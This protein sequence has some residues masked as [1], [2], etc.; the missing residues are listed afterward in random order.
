MPASTQETLHHRHGW[1]EIENSL[2]PRMTLGVI[3]F[4]KDSRLGRGVDGEFVVWEARFWEAE[5]DS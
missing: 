3:E 4:D 5:A 2:I 1:I